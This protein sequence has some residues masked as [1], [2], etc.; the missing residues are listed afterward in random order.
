M[1]YLLDTEIKE[2]EE[3]SEVRLTVEKEMEDANLEDE[4]L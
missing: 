3:S 2:V 1:P 4:V